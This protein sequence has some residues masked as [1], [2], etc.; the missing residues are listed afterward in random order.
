MPSSASRAIRK[1]LPFVSTAC[2]VLLALPTASSAQSGAQN[3]RVSMT[4]TLTLEYRGNNQNGLDGDDS[5]G[6]LLN[7]L[8]LNGNAGNLATAVR[9][10]SFAFENAND[11]YRST[12]QLERIN[13]R[14]RVGQLRFEV[15]DFYQQLGRGAVLSMRKIDEQGLDVALRGGWIAHEAD[16]HRALVFAG[17][18]NPV[19][20]DAVTQRYVEPTQDVLAGGELLVTAVDGFEFGVM[21]LYAEP[22]DTDWDDQFDIAMALPAGPLR[23]RALQNLDAI[24]RR[25]HGETVGASFSMPS[26]VDW[27]ALYAEGAWQS[28]TIL[29]EEQNGSTIYGTADLRFDDYNLLLEGIRVDTMSVLASNNNVTTQPFLYFA[30]PSLERFDQEVLIFDHYQ[31]GRVRAER[32]ISALDLS[33]NVNGMVRYTNPGEDNELRQV[34]GYAGYE[35]YYQNGLSRLVMNGGYRDETSTRGEDAQFKT[36]R[37]F[38]VDWLQSISGPWSLHVQSFNEFRTLGDDPY[39][40]GS[41]LFGLERASTGALTFEFG[42]DTTNETEG[43]TNF[44]YA[45]ILQWFIDD[46]FTLQ[47]TG[48]TQRGGI[49]CIN[50]I[51]RNYPG[52]AGGSLVLITRL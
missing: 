43:V 17:R 21:G 18:S 46:R 27:L 4:D 22:G 32:Y 35:L 13:I 19:N 36:L 2:L 5:Y 49:K 3:T 26:A 8:N 28:R 14:Y 41:T 25:D 23:D 33:L 39:Q 24:P 44:F 51:C 48:G 6:A 42:Y 16:T 50:G 12:A 29:G 30:P 15:G 11:L 45:G 9:I 10:D 31:G 40:R 7:R 20:I 37:H 47:A 1:P 38:D 52:F 34:H